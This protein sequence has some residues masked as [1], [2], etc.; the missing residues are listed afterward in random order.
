LAKQKEEESNKL[1]RQHQSRKV[2]QVKTAKQ[3]K[4]AAIASRQLASRME[5]KLKEHSKKT[6]MELDEI[7][8]LLEEEEKEELMEEIAKKLAEQITDR[9]ERI[10]TKLVK[11]EFFENESIDFVRETLKQNEKAFQQRILKRDQ[12]RH[13]I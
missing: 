3:S 2:Q 9:Q 6:Q 8:M 4:E 12:D 13:Q 5:A 7:K 10:L 11:K 1:I